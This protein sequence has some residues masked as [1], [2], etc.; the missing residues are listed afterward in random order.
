MNRKVKE[1]SESDNK[2]SDKQTELG[3]IHRRRVHTLLSVCT[4]RPT[5]VAVVCSSTTLSPHCS[6]S[7][8]N[9]TAL[10][11]RTTITL[12]DHQ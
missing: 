2:Q 4:T 1:E 7:N 5:A 3:A 12:I 11:D 8:F 6:A 9:L 10:I